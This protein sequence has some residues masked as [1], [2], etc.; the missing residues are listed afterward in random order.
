MEAVRELLVEELQDLYHAENQLVK[1]LPKMARAAHNPKLRECFEK[2]LQQTENQI[3]RLTAAFELLGA[4]PKGKP[5][6][7][8]AGLIEEGQEQIEQGTGQGELSADL[9][10]IGA[11]QKIEHY[12]IAGYGTVRTLA[13]VLGENEVRKLLIQTLGEEEGADRLL[14]EVGKPLL[15]QAASGNGRAERPSSQSAGS[16]TATTEKTRA[17]TRPANARQS[18]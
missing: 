7:G 10:L 12:E 17:R 13:E 9:S 2:H 5:C 14:T 4:D 16:A 3:A 6:R 15:Q 11:A 1:A 8:M 18:A